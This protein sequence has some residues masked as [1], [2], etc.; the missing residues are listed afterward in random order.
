MESSQ[1]KKSTI[2]NPNAFDVSDELNM[3]KKL[4]KLFHILFLCHRTV[5]FPLPFV[6]SFSPAGGVLLGVF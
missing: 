6:L 2:P 5:L 1:E 4:E 3:K